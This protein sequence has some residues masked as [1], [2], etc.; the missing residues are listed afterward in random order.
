MAAVQDLFGEAL[1]FLPA[2][3][4]GVERLHASTQVN[5]VA[6][7]AGRKHEVIH[8]NTYI[9][10]AYLEHSKTKS[11]L[12]TEMFGKSKRQAGQLLSQRILDSTLTGRPV[13]NG[14]GP[15]AVREKT[16]TIEP[17][18]IVVDTW[19]VERLYFYFC[20]VSY[21]SVGDAWG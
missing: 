10:S 2:S 16:Q 17:L 12:E 9:M 8:Q 6:L 3:S 1:L 18:G 21:F 14:H 19:F 5:S 7:K 15:G 13:T 20:I 11:T 4:V